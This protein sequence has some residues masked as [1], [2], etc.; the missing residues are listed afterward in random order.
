M[1]YEDL[2]VGMKYAGPSLTVTEA[3]I[4]LFGQLTLN[5]NPIH[6]NAHFAGKFEFGKRIAQG[7]LTSSLAVGNLGPF[8][9]G[10]TPEGIATRLEDSYG[11]RAPVFLGDS[12]TTELEILEKEPHSRFGVVKVG[13]S[14]CKQDGTA[15]MQGWTK[16]GLHYKANQ[17]EIRKKM[18][19]A[20]P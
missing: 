8:L 2:K 3:H 6:M 7:M 17:A 15:V 5:L 19:A 10:D 4:V 12:I 14:T 16:L 11:Y 9:N 18:E 1:Y 20:A 13:Y